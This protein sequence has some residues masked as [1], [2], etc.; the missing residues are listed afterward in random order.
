LAKRIPQR[1]WLRLSLVEKSDHWHHRLLRPRRE[2]PRDSRAADQRDELA[3]FQLIELHS[4]PA[5]QEHLI[6]CQGHAAIKL[7]S[8]G[9]F[10]PAADRCLLPF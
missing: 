4:V 5:T 9:R 8:V 6:V 3:S 7:G 1:Q 10:C 2:R